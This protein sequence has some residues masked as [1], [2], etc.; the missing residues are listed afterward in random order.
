MGSK[1]M[2]TVV[3]LLLAI[4][5]SAIGASWYTAQKMDEYIQLSLENINRSNV[6]KAS[7]YPKSSW[8]FTRNGVL[9][10]V[11]FNQ[12]MRSNA[13]AGPV[14]IDDPRSLER[15]KER[16]AAPLPKRSDE[17]VQLFINVSNSMFPFM[18][19]GDAALDMSRGTASELVQQ[20][21]IPAELPIAFTWKYSALTQA[22]KMRLSMDHWSINQPHQSVDVGAAEVSLK[23]DINDELELD[24]GWRGLKVVF[25]QSLQNGFE[26][27]PIEGNSLIRNFS[28]ILIAPEGHM[29]LNGFRLSAPDLKVDMGKVQ[30][31]SVMYETLAE[32][33]PLLNMK[34]NIALDKFLFDSP[35]E[36]FHL[37]DLSFGLVFSG[38]NKQGVEELV[39]EMR[40]EQPDFVQV[41][42]SLN[43]ITSKVLRLDLANC[44]MKLNQGRVTASGY[45]ASLPFEVEQLIRARAAATPDPLKFML[46][47][48][49]S[50]SA[51]SNALTAL[52][53]DMRQQL[54]QLRQQGFVKADSKGVSSH[55][56]LRGGTLTANDKLI[57]TSVP[58]P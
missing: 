38:L 41:M 32:T 20:K 39:Q 45:L 9:H 23:G 6:M 50:I 19:S 51:E 40:A 42:K 26:V 34:H 28:G 14:N 16:A 44:Q 56:L 57:P 35:Q 53:A 49:L 13:E 33:S 36:H 27:L 48:D 30:F 11:I 18:V 21:S 8:P 15:A 31:D 22:F 10:V 3:G 4:V 47:G 29:T 17:P 58:N 24:Y 37:N 1:I 25:S 43:K 2:L 54:D 12:H 55:L 46:Q 52:P 7:W 5:V